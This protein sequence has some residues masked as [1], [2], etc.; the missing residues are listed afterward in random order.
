M[1]IRLAA[2]LQTDSIVDG[3]GIRTVIWTQGCMHNCHGCHNPETH[4]FNKGFL[5]DVEKVKEEI[6]SIKYQDGITLSGGDPL[7]QVEPILEIAKYAKQINLNIWCYTGFTFEELLEKSKKDEKLFEL[8]QNIDV[9]VDGKFD[10]NK[11]SMNL[12]F[13][14]SSNQRIIDIKKS[15]KNNEIITID[16]FKIK[17][18]YTIYTNIQNISKGIF[19]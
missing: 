5:V 14:G 19:I 4:D 10:E 6:S 15:L 18:K 13:R 3:E 12:P 17:Q 8:L 9:L 16:K 11:K 7:Y 1:K 2:P